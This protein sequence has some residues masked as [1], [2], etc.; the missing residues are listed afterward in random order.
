MVFVVCRQWC[1]QSHDIWSHV[2]WFIHRVH[3]TKASWKRKLCCCSTRME[4][5]AFNIEVGVDEIGFQLSLR[6]FGMCQ[7]FVS[8]CSLSLSLKWKDIGFVRKIA[9]INPFKKISLLMMVDLLISPR[10][11][12]YYFTNRTWCKCYIYVTYRTYTWHLADVTSRTCCMST[13]RQQ[14]CMSMHLG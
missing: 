13:L 7:S 11:C 5:D 9:E 8:T 2:V 4:V 1:H 12:E 14:R 10:K 3:W 6:T